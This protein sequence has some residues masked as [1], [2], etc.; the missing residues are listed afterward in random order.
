MAMRI[1]LLGAPG[2]GKG[3]QGERLRERLGAPL[4]STG[5]MLRG[6]I[7]EGGPLAEK[8]R[9]YVNTGALVPDEAILEMVSAR[10]SQPDTAGGFILDGFPR[11]I[12]QAAGL[13][14]LLEEKGIRIDRVL[15]LD[16]NRKVLIER[17]TSRWICPECGSIFN[18]LTQPPARAGVCD[19]CGQKLMQREDDTEETAKRRLNV[20][21]SS[22]APLIDYYDA[23]HLLSIVNG[24]GAMEA[25]LDRAV[26][27]LAKRQEAP[28]AR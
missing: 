8:V 14:L 12:P 16:V 3:T 18:V 26:A 7:A 22:T 27:A 2:S 24:E 6:T 5:D 21:E 4:I 17:L 9:S 1:I 23:R 28:P 10:L 11:S 15:K 20:Y 19:R 25:V 13:D